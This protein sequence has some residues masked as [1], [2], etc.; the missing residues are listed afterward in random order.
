MS[1]NWKYLMKLKY[2]ENVCVHNLILIYFECFTTWMAPSFDVEHFIKRKQIVFISYIQAYY[3][4]IYKY[5]RKEK[6][7]KLMHQ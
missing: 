6:K 5:N 7:K 3:L 2:K 4:S 1:D